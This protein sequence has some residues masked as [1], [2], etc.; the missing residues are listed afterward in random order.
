MVDLAR[1]IDFDVNANFKMKAKLI[2]LFGWLSRHIAQ[3]L[4]KITQWFKAKYAVVYKNLF[5][6]VSDRLSVCCFTTNEQVFS[7]VSWRGHVTFGEMMMSV[8]Y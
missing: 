8:L 6:W 3:L 2:M 1:I 5:L 7:T 4:K